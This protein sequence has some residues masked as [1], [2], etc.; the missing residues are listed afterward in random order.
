MIDVSRNPPK[1]YAILLFSGMHGPYSQ[2]VSAIEGILTF[3]IGLKERR[4]IA[5]RFRVSSFST[6]LAVALG[7][8]EMK[9]FGELVFLSSSGFASMMMERLS[10]DFGKKCK[11]QFSVY[12]APQIST[13]EKP[14]WMPKNE[15][16]SPQKPWWSHIT[17]C[18]LRTQPWS[19]PTALFWWTTRQSMKSVAEIWT[20]IGD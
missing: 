20:S 5:I 1:T 13:C 19:I 7:S 8:S 17:R 9:S 11:L 10:V 3:P 16:N 2:W 14:A 15:F 18:Y 12:P 4:S 6:H